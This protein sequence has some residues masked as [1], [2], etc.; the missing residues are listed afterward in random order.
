MAKNKKARKNTPV[1]FVPK[2]KLFFSSNGKKHNNKTDSEQYPNN[3]LKLGVEVHNVRN[4]FFLL[5]M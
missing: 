2:D 3:N 5:V 4:Y 1:I